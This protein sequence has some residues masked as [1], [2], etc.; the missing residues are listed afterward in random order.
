M[1]K[2][3]KR[4]VAQVLGLV[5]YATGVAYRTGSNG[6]GLIQYLKEWADK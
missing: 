5:C 1:K 3:L 2:M 6:L 4:G